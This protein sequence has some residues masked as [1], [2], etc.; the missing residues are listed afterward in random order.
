MLWK[1]KKTYIL[2]LTISKAT[3]SVESR[4]L[5]NKREQVVYKGIESFICQHSPRQ[6]SHTLHLIVDKQLGCHHDKPWGGRSASTK[7]S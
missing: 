2:K 3:Q 6:M 5:D 1:Q 4:H 7:F